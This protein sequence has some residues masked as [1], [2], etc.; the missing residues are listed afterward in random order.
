MEV[1]T[2]DQEEENH[3]GKHVQCVSSFNCS[4]FGKHLNLL[5]QKHQIG[6]FQS[7]YFNSKFDVW[8]QVW[9]L[10]TTSLIS[11]VE[12]VSRNELQNVVGLINTQLH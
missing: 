8:T 7:K 11:V 10:V 2:L 5:E 12:C 1:H 4:T 6:L 3:N 9:A